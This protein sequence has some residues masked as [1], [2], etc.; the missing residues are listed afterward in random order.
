MYIVLVT[1]PPKVI[2]HCMQRC[3]NLRIPLKN[4]EVVLPPLGKAGFLHKNHFALPLPTLHL[5]IVLKLN[6]GVTLC[7]NLLRRTLLIIGGIGVVAVRLESIAC[8]FVTDQRLVLA[9]VR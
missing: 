7:L 3:R 6:N 5:I 8:G 2:H 1:V 9:D 4:S